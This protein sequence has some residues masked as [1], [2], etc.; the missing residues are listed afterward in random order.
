MLKELSQ[1]S[2]RLLKSLHW[3]LLLPKDLKGLEKGGWLAENTMAGSQLIERNHLIQK[4]ETDLNGTMS[5]LTA[6]SN[7]NEQ[8][9][10]TCS[11]APT[12]LPDLLKSRLQ[13]QPC[14]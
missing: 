14:Y 7:G 1:E 3:M 11:N 12:P 10:V 8:I 2:I 6:T 4:R 9:P 13:V 5:N